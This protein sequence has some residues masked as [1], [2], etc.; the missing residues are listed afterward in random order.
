MNNNFD[1]NNIP[2]ITSLNSL[3][4]ELHRIYDSTLNEEAK[5]EYTGKV[6]ENFQCKP[7][8][9]AKYITYNPAG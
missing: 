9:W 4:K 5:R 7:E 6:L 8:E 1:I 2:K 3:A